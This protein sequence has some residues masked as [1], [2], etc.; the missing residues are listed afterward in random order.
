MAIQT[1]VIWDLA[2]SQQYE[3]IVK[4]RAAEMADLQTAPPSVAQNPDGTLTYI[5][6][7]VDML[8]AESWIDFVEQYS[9]IS[10]TI[11]QTP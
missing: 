9:P 3:T 7:W 2:I 11:E 6:S 5:R 1:L 10:A 8:A 4:Q